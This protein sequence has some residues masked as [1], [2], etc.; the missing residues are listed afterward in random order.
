MNQRVAK[1]PRRYSRRN[2]REYLEEVA[3]WPFRMRFR[4][5]WHIIFTKPSPHSKA[6]LWERR[7][8]VKGA[9]E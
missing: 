7:K 1:K 3:T 2:W 8:P 9:K 6:G 5:A 4:L